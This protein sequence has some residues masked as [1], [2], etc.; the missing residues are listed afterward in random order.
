M[1]LRVVKSID[2]YLEVILEVKNAFKSEVWF[3]GQNNASHYLIPSLFREKSIVGIDN[4]VKNDYEYKKSDA[5]MKDDFT[6]LEK[7]ILAYDR[8]MKP[9]NNP[10]KVDYFY[11]MQ[12]YDIPTRLLDF[13]KSELI[14]LYFSLSKKSKSKMNLDDEIS[15]FFDNTDGSS[16][17]GSSVFCIDPYYTNLNTTG[18]EIIYDLSV[19]DFDI[20]EKIDLPI[21]IKTSFDDKRLVAQ[22]GVFVFFGY[23]Y[24][25]YEDYYPL[26]K[27][28]YKIFIPN[29]LRK[30]MFEELK[31]KFKITHSVIFPDIKGISLEII[32]E[33]ENKYVEDCDRVFK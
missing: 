31:N 33:I 20:L 13:S 10:N 1:E 4:V 8:L 21:C 22:H 3:R 32:D 15:S 30:E 25:N 5:I 29:S 24:R 12:H 14:A 9:Q 11:L 17:Y 18:K 6:A 16:K 28:I 19:N 27:R 2:E 26:N 23:N 7:F